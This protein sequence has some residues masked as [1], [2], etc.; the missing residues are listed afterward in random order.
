RLGMPPLQF[1]RFSWGGFDSYL[2]TGRNIG[3][4]THELIVLPVFGWVLPATC[5]GSRQH[6]DSLATNRGS[7]RESNGRLSADRIFLGREVSVGASLACGVALL[8]CRD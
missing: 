7:S 1:A 5:I 3:K 8:R 2:D 6:S 4:N